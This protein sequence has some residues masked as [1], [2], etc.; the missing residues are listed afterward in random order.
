VLAILAATAGV[1][2]AQKAPASAPASG[3]ASAPASSVVEVGKVPSEFAK[4]IDAAMQLPVGEERLK[5]FVTVGIEWS[6]KE[7]IPAMSWASKLRR[8]LFPP[9]ATLQVPMKVSYAL[10]KGKDARIVAEWFISPKCDAGEKG[11]WFYD[12]VQMWGEVDSDSALAWA[13]RMPK[14]T[15][16]DLRFK[17]FLALGNGWIAKVKKSGGSLDG[18]ELFSRIESR[19]DRLA[20]V[21]G[22]ATKGTDIP[23]ATAWVK[24]LEPGEARL[25]AT[26][27]AQ[28]WEKIFNDGGK[29]DEASIKKWLDQLPLSNA[30]KEEVLKNQSKLQWS[31]KVLA[32]YRSK[33]AE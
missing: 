27:I 28:Q 14:D 3:P 22:A 5:A 30:D 13:L 25:A 7:P 23:T 19:D 2:H 21:M 32:P 11:H 29:R 9:S 16:A 6:Q 31:P 17:C 33:N 18:S 4:V 15:D 8:D 24:K 20:A 12:L 26:V 1:V 10:G